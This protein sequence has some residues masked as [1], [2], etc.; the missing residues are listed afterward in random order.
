MTTLTTI[1]GSTPSRRRDAEAADD[2]GTEM[3][4][5][6][7]ALCF[8]VH[9]GKLQILLITSRDTGRWVIPKG[10][11]I[12][13]L[14]PADSAAEEAWEEAGAVGSVQHLAIGSF[15]YA[16]RL[17]ARPARPCLVEVFP[18][19][20][21]RMAERFPERGQRRRKW[22]SPAKAA[23]KVHEP[24]LARMLADFLPPGAASRDAGRELGRD[25]G[26]SSG[27]DA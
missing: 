5:Q 15:A 17:R 10:G 27:A 22:F 24:E 25:P 3:L 8:R 1:T 21:E 4:R 26:R 9:R 18:L 20:V 23:A 13:G 14:G 11:L 19:K 2:G 7:G 12:A 6:I 16:K